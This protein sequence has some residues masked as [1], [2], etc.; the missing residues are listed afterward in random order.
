MA[1]V[2]PEILFEYKSSREI[3]ISI[4]LIDWS[5]RDSCHILDYL[6]RQDT[7]REL[8]EIVWIEYYDKRQR[9]IEKGLREYTDSKLHPIVDKWIIL[10]MPKGIYYHKHFM[11]NIGILVSSGRIVTFC[12]SDA[13]MEPTFINSIISSF[14]ECEDIVLHMDEVRNINRKFYPFSYP[15]FDE[16]I[17][18]GCINWNSGRPRG[19][20]DLSDPIHLRNYGACMSALRRD[21]I[22]IGGADE[23][24][25]Y[26]GHICGVYDMTFRLVNLGKK[27]I[28]HEK[29]WIYHT[30][31]PRQS[32]RW[33]YL[34]P[35]DGRHMSTTA[36]KI[37]DSGRT[38]PLVENR[39]I[40]ELRENGGA[41]RGYDALLYKAMPDKETLERWKVRQNIR[42]I[43]E[44]I[45]IT[46]RD[47]IGQ[48]V[49]IRKIY[50]AVKKPDITIKKLIAQC[51]LFLIL[52]VMIIRQFYIKVSVPSRG[53]FKFEGRQRGVIKRIYSLYVFFIKIWKYDRQLIKLCRRCLERL[54]MQGVKSVVIFGDGDI[55]KILSILAMPLPLK[56]VDISDD[57]QNLKNLNQEGEK[58]IIASLVN[59]KNRIDRIKEVGFEEERIV[60]L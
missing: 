59:I 16:V 60:T 24:I 45:F 52:F 33:N 36:L 55:A 32:G 5:V 39:A 40:R 44:N 19:L 3:I 42:Y 9:E 11:Y 28:W 51:R 14:S 58:I 37:M 7:D 17:R 13:F 46:T 15:S 25:D 6:N 18:I 30:W 57:S 31:H 10:N 2:K 54:Y 12:D 29:E 34:G 1:E 21:L 35:H 23:H 26:L 20:V 8:Y 53:R 41:I 43:I 27:E 22:S 49:C 56:I 50:Y 47:W 48:Q 4:I 38:M